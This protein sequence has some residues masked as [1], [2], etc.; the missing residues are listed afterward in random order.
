MSVSLFLSNFLLLIHFPTHWSIDSQDLFNL[1]SWD[2]QS[3]KSS[4]KNSAKILQ[5]LQKLQM[6]QKF[7]HSANVAKVLQKFCKSSAKVPQKFCKSSANIAKVLQKISKSS[8]KILQKFCKICKSSAKVPKVLQ[9]PYIPHFTIPSFVIHF[10][11]FFSIF[12]CLNHLQ[13]PKV[14]TYCRLWT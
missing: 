6:F 8:A 9:N 7:Q 10:L 14:G 13:S 5:K 12:F 3:S 2:F 4:A 11:D 1:N